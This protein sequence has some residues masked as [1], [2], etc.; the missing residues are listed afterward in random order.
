MGSRAIRLNNVSEYHELDL[1]HFGH[2]YSN[3]Y[4]CH[5]ALAKTILL[6]S[7]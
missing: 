6:L 7:P 2:Q 1:E 4:T 5:P 3:Q